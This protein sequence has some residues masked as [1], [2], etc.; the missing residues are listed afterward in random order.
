MIPVRGFEGRKVALFGL[1][2]SGIA[3]AKALAAGGAHPICWDDNE[4]SLAKAA[5]EGLALADLTAADWSAFAALVLSPGVPLTHPVPHPLGGLAKAAGVPII[6]DIELFC[7]ERQRIAPQAPVVAVTGT[8]GKSTTVALI[9]HVL[10]EAGRNVE[11]GGNFG[12]PILSLEPPRMDRVHVLECSSFQIELAPSLA[13]TV[14]VLLNISPDHLDRHGTL[15]RYAE[16]KSRL[17][18]AADVAVIGVDDSRSS[19][20][21]DHLEQAGRKVIR[22]SVR[23]PLADGI[24]VRGGGIYAVAAGAEEEIARLDGIRT[25]RGDHNAQNAAAAAAVARSLGVGDEEITK[26]LTTFPGLAHRMEEVGKVGRILFVNDSKATNSD[27]T[28]RALASFNHLYWIVGGRPKSDGIETLAP[29]FPRVAKAFLIGES[30]ETFART[31]EGRVSYEISETL[32][33]AVAAAI[34]VAMDSNEEEPVVLL[35][36]AAASYDQFNN[37]AERGDKFREIVAR[38]SKNVEAEAAK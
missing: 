21:A 3:T 35:S 22:V 19:M 20:I 9:A 26:A 38:A 13:P 25:L 23:N 15:E 8:N 10:R 36:P 27:A 2:G 29:L 12:P 30:A 37:F 17:V 31:L 7:L 1:G 5:A 6:G 33:R 24:V 16:I 28:A 14:G 18:G 34:G 4:A 11:L 32:E